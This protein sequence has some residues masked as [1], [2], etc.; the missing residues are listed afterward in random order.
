MIRLSP[1]LTEERDVPLGMGVTIRLRPVTYSGI[2]AV[3]QRAFRQARARL[4]AVSALGAEA[5]DAA[6]MN[7]GAD[8]EAIAAYNDE[9]V[10]V[11][12]ELMLDALVARFAVSWE[13]VAN[14]TGE[15]AAPL[16]PE[17]WRMLRE[18]FPFMADLVRAALHRPVNLA[19]AEGN[20]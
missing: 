11:A 7:G 12:E 15:A 18:G 1:L 4:A 5:L 16:T 2:K 10:G 8:P 13:G 19:A 6:S 14:E 3:E 9:I 20:A 17:N